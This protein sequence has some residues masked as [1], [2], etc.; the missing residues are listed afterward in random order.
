MALL[1]V[2]GNKASNASH[3]SAYSFFLVFFVYT[4]PFLMQR[5]GVVQ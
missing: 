3:P 4:N 1:L 5:L 2:L